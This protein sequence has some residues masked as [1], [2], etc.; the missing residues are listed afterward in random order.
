MHAQFLD[1]TGED[2]IDCNDSSKK[3]LDKLVALSED[4]CGL[5]LS[6]EDDHEQGLFETV[7]GG[8]VS[9][10]MTELRERVGADENLTY[11]EDTDNEVE[12]F[13]IMT[14]WKAD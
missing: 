6:F 4:G 14:Y 10:F 7:F 3:I 2:D 9:G 11:K 5:R 12:F 1:G 8:H 13:A